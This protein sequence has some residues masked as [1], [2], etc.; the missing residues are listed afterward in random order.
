MIQEEALIREEL[1]R[2]P[3]EMRKN[4]K[5]VMKGMEEDNDDSDLE[6]VDQVDWVESSNAKELL[7]T[8]LKDATVVLH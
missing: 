7:G 3:A 4:V 8:G 5:V 1:A 2:L 6:G